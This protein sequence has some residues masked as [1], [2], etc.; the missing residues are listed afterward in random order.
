LAGYEKHEEYEKYI[1]RL[2]YSN[3]STWS[4]IHEKVQL[5]SQQKYLLSS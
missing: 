1:Y 5:R 3:W 4:C 2:V